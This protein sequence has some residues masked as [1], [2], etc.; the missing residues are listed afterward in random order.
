MHGT[1]HHFLIPLIFTGDILSLKLKEKIISF[2]V[3]NVFPCE[4]LIARNN[5]ILTLTIFFACLFIFI[6]QTKLSID[7][8]WNVFYKKKSEHQSRFLYKYI[9]WIIIFLPCS[10]LST[11]Y[12]IG[13]KKTRD[14]NEAIIFFDIVYG[15]QSSWFL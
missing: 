14:C 9:Q 13:R 10:S 8:C 1:K 12:F 6:S 7:A 3:S 2:L 15:C 5:F 11:T 4:V